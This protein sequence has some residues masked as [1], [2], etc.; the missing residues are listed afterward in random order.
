MTEALFKLNR[1]FL[2]GK[3]LLLETHVEKTL[4]I[5]LSLQY[6]LNF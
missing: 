2:E 6:F 1:N 4:M 3:L 5:Y